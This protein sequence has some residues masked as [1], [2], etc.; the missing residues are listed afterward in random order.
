MLENTHVK[1]ITQK[2]SKKG[3]SLVEEVDNAHSCIEFFLERNEMFSP[4]SLICAL[5]TVRRKP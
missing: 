3:Y 2:F 4:I 1:T 5:K